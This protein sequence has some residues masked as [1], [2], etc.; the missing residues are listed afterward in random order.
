MA[1]AKEGNARKVERLIKCPGVD[2][3]HAYRGIMDGPMILGNHTSLYL[4]S[5]YGHEEVVEVLLQH[6]RIDVNHKD[7]NNRTSLSMAIL[8]GYLPI[9]MRLLNDSRTN[10]NLGGA[11]SSR[12]PV[13]TSPLFMASASGYVDLVEKLISHPEIEINKDSDPYGL[14]ATPLMM[15]SQEGD[16]KMV[17]VLL[18][19]PQIATNKAT[20]KSGM[21]ALLIASQRGYVDVVQMLLTNQDVN[22]NQANL[23]GQTPLFMASKNGHVDVVKTLL[24]DQR[25]DVNQAGF[26]YVFQAE[27]QRKA[28]P[29]IVAIDG[30]SS[31]R[32]SPYL[33]VVKTLLSD[34]RVDVNQA[35]EEGVPPLFWASSVPSFMRGYDASLITVKLLLAHQ[36]LDPS[37]FGSNSRQYR[38]N[39]IIIAAKIGNLEVVQLLLRCPKVVLG[40]KDS[41]GMSE[42][43]YARQEIQGT[44]TV[45]FELASQVAEAIESR[46]T[47][48]EQGHTC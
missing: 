38:S 43:D 25:V 29:L 34:Q 20:L 26:T 4:A 33:E 48:L 9:A 1:A 17:K 36:S 19:H 21:T 3:N 13:N 8:R 27:K 41:N 32:I 42:L 10:V 2:I 11:M 18:S 45:P 15:A 16:V 31:R 12:G 24:A 23:K 22:V 30:L 5:R 28:T 39:A 46:Q 44:R 40:M 7:M 37:K 14:A 6:P 47:L 35:D